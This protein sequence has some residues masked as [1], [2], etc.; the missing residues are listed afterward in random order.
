MKFKAVK[1]ISF[2]LFIIFIPSI[3]FSQTISL[4]GPL[5][6][7]AVPEGD[8]FAK[9]VLV[10]PWDMSQKRDFGW[11]EKFVGTSVQ[12][13]NGIWNGTYQQ[14]GGYVFPLFPGFKGALQAEGFQG[15]LSLPKYGINHPI[16]ASKYTLLSYR[17]TH[18]DR[19]A[20]AIYWKTDGSTHYWPD[21]SQLGSSV[22]CMYHYPVGAFGPCYLHEGWKLYSFDMTNTQGEFEQAIG[23][24][25]GDIFALRID[26]SN[27]GSVGSTAQ[28]DWIR[29]VDPSSGQNHT[30][31]WNSS[32]VQ[33]GHVVSVYMDNNNT[34]YDGTHMQRFTYGA[35]PG[36]YTFN[37][38]ILPPGEYYFYVTV[39]EINP[40]TGQLNLLSTSGYSGQLSIN[41]APNPFFKK[42]T[43]KTGEKYSKSVVGNMWDMQD[44]ADVANLPSSSW[45]YVWRQ[46]SNH[47]FLNGIFQAVA[48]LP[49]N[50]ALHTDAQVHLNV[51]QSEP[52]DT[53]KYRYITY[54]IGADNALFPSISDMIAGGFVTRVNAWDENIIDD[55][56]RPQAHLLYEGINTYTVDLWDNSGIQDG[57]PYRYNRY[58]KN[59][60]IDPLETSIY[61]WFYIENVKLSADNR[62]INNR[63]KIKWKV[64]DSDSPTYN[65]SIYYD[66][67]NK[68]FN[69]ELITT[70]NNLPVGKSDY[71]WDTTGVAEGRYYFY[72][73]VDDGINTSRIYSPVD[74]VIGEVASLSGIN[75][76]LD[77]DGDGSSDP[78]VFRPNATGSYHVKRSALGNYSFNWG[79]SSYTPIH[80]DFD[81]DGKTDYGLISDLG[82]EFLYWYVLYSSTGGLYSRIW[83]YSD[84][85][86]KIAIGDY[87]GNG[88]DE[89]GIY[90]NGEWWILDENNNVTTE[91]WGGAGD[92]PVPRDFDGDGKDDLAYWRPSTGN[93]V[94]KYSGFDTGHIQHQSQTFQWGLSTHQLVPADWTGDNR[95]DLGVWDPLTGTWYIK[96]IATGN[97]ETLAWGLSTFKPVVGDFNGDGTL[98]FTVYDPATGLWYH[99]YRN[100]ENS[101]VSWGV[102]GDLIPVRN[103]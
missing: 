65:V 18:S 39:H 26:P 44:E 45:H 19:S 43:Q 91:N 29:L 78:V 50:G 5:S 101:T 58:Q 35:N 97:T 67:D 37:T 8:D 59:F 7:L 46:F 11:E 94:I 22:D 68:D 41:D 36:F 73:I 30:I 69:G 85:V 66:I 72:L 20:Y 21:G 4:T 93:W 28:F 38:A 27:Q 48:D 40:A 12:T 23:T 61:T 49:Y 52:I 79:N 102:P 31:T 57:K 84:G 90:R 87:N 96:D 92:K 63:F 53:Y 33:L 54:R 2:T 17:S 62:P 70:L 82:T 88:K 95:A 55:G 103:D 98:D 9:N 1:K 80:G 77:Y 42:P 25:S 89:L 47:S 86:D 81:G 83:G 10:N 60:R 99:N 64:R 6:D 15:N 56:Y 71:V 14:S 16:D 76:P 24:W 74:I 51:S 3:L 32:G 34:G 13:I 100:T 75:P